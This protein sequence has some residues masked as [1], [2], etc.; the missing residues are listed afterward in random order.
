MRTFFSVLFCII[1]GLAAIPFGWMG[2]ILIIHLVGIYLLPSKGHPPDISGPLRVFLWSGGIGLG[3]LI[4]AALFN[5]ETVSDWLEYMG[6]P[7][8]E[9]EANWTGGAVCKVCGGTGERRTYAPGYSGQERFLYGGL[10]PCNICDSKGY[11]GREPPRKVQKKRQIEASR[12]MGHVS[13]STPP[14]D[15]PWWE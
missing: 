5:S 11:I 14:P 1:A 12:D 13:R 3:S 7:E 15:K 9:E 2:L 8:D 10:I 6:G 4:L